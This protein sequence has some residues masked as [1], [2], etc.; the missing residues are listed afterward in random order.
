MTGI[1]SSVVTNFW[2]GEW[3]RSA[4]ATGTDTP[5]LS[6]VAGTASFSVTSTVGHIAVSVKNC[7]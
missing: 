7:T 6:S 4:N 5:T 3:R 2:Y 1:T